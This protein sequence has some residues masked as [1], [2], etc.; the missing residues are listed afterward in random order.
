V[1]GRGWWREALVAVAAAEEEKEVDEEV[2][3]ARLVLQ[4]GARA[5]AHHQ[6]PRPLR[7]KLVERGGRL[8]RHAQLQQVSHLS[9]V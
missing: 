3:A 9:R 1:E 2:E 8:L 7:G 5:R 4:K 6:P